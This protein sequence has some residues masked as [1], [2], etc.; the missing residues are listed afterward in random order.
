MTHYCCAFGGAASGCGN[1]TALVTYIGENI[2][3]VGPVLEEALER[4]EIT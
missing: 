2:D 3:N 4:R 1:N